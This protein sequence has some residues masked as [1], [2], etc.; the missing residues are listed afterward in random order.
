MTPSHP[1]STSIHSALKQTAHRVS[2]HRPFSPPLLAFFSSVSHKTSNESRDGRRNDV[3]ELNVV[4]WLPCAQCNCL[5]YLD[6]VSVN[7]TSSHTSTMFY[8]SLTPLFPNIALRQDICNYSE[9]AAWATW[10]ESSRPAV[11][12]LSIAVHEHG[13]MVR[14]SGAPCR[15]PQ[16]WCLAEKTSAQYVSKTVRNDSYGLRCSQELIHCLKCRCR[17]QSLVF[18]HIHPKSRA[19]LFSAIPKHHQGSSSHNLALSPPIAI[20]AFR[21]L[22][23]RVPKCG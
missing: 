10:G 7:R 19:T 17:A 9:T 6:V 16:L 22:L 23:F 5:P 3:V 20:A 21:S 11:A 13:L 8:D 18:H 15:P 1:N 12:L 2:R 4:C 14:R